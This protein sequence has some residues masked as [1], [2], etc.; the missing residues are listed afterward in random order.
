MSSVNQL[1]RQHFS[2][3]RSPSA[4]VKV[5]KDECT[6]SFDNPESKDGLYICLNTF[7]GFGKKHV[8]RHFRKTGNAVFLRYRRVKRKSTEVK[9][10]PN[11]KGPTR[12]AIGTEDGFSADAK[13]FQVEELTS[14]VI[15]PDWDE[16]DLPNPD[17]PEIVQMSVAAIMSADDAWK[18]MEAAALSNTWDGEM[19]AVS[20][21]A[22]NLLQLDNGR[23]IPPSG[24]KCDKCELTS[25][26]W[27]NLTDG[28]ILC[29]RKFFDGS[30]GNNH[31]VEYY[32]QTKYPLAVKLG[33][34]TPEGADVFSYDEDDMVID[35][36]L[37]EHLAHWGINVTK[38][39][40]T[41]KTMIELEID[42]NQKMEYDTIQ[43]SGSQLTPQFGPG[44][45]GIHNLGNSC[46]MN[47]V[48]QV[49]FAIPD[50]QRRFSAPAETIFQDAAAND[51]TEDFTVQMAKFARGLLSGD[52]S[53]PDAG[54]GEGDVVL[55]SGIRPW[56][57][58]SLIGKGHAEFATKRQQDAQEFFLHVIDAMEQNNRNGANPCDAFKFKVEDRI[59]CGSSKKVKY[60]YRSDYLLPLQIPREAA[61]NK[62]EVSEY[63]EKVAA[64]EAAGGKVNATELPLV[65]PRIP[66]EACLQC[67]ARPDIIEGFYS[68]ATKSTTTAT[69]TT[70][71]A[72]FPEYLLVQ[73][74]KFTIGSDWVP[75]KLDVAVAM[76]DKIDLSAIRGMGIQPGEEE[77]PEEA[78]APSAAGGG[79][80]APPAP[81]IDET[82]VMQLADMGFPIEGCKKAVFHTNNTGIEAAMNW[83]MEHM[84]DDDFSSPFS[85][86]NASGAPAEDPVDEEHLGMI[87]S[88]GFTLNQA[89]KALKVTKNNLEQAMEWIFAHADD[90]CDDVDVAPTVPTE[91]VPADGAASSAAYR[92]GPGNYE[93][94]SIISHMG[95]SHM[96][97]HYVAHI[98]KD[99]QWYIFNDEKVAKSENPPIELGYLYLYRRC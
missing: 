40:K 57:F 59:Q 98:K 20:K 24:W 68:S 55:T 74:K 56:M 79:V 23:K 84:G 4:G 72:T 3:I 39:R 16:V 19:R 13:D 33:T 63:E 78:T 64:I 83:V 48:M 41:E 44:F 70:R 93:L 81:A 89:K 47:S 38:M 71:L 87:V 73:L 28:A 32:D 67:F 37:S 10:P 69:K 52:Y 35:P 36:K 51:P 14:L 92:D 29:G 26:L 54:A 66:F 85:V 77:L 97:G 30:G 5:H 1:L 25:N 15:L 50:F 6:Y 90:P 75:K 65:R 86:P 88:M 8:E 12:L 45:T 46:Y 18:A 61:M 53:F 22:E 95:T 11:K 62:D 60:C 42:L 76:P 21:Y 49:L 94:S 7:L 43:E 2:R 99:G 96:V 80:S 31:A 91:D 9:E 58:R 82:V 17:L 34:I 27:L